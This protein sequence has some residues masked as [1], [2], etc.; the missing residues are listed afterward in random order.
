MTNDQTTFIVTLELDQTRLDRY[1]A[2]EL[3]LSRNQVRKLLEAGAITVNDQIADKAGMH[4]CAGNRVVVDQQ[5]SQQLHTVIPNDQIDIPILFQDNDLLIVNKPANMGVHPLGPQENNTVLNGLI[6]KFPQIQGVGE[7]GLRSGI[8]HRLD[9][10][11]TGTLMIALTDIGYRYGRKAITDKQYT[12]KQYRAIIHGKPLVNDLL[13]HRNLIISQHK[14][15]KVSVIR[16]ANPQ[17][18]HCSLAYQLLYTVGP[19]SYVQVDLYTGFLHQIRVMLAD[20]GHPVL[21]DTQY[22]SPM[23]DRPILLHAYRLKFGAMDVIAP[24]PDE[25]K[26]ALNPA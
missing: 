26:H 15:A 5:T 14:P 11:T 6:A 2:D 20:L 10:Q 16:D 21:G 12:L 22:G 24:I 19:D 9:L 4:L 23:T 7:G 18:R 17:S 13:L 8:V 3:S 25:M 1:I